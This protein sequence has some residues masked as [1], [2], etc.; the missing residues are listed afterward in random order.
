MDLGLL[1][2]IALTT[3][4]TRDG[5]QSSGL[6]MNWRIATQLVYEDIGD[7]RRAYRELYEMRKKTIAGRLKS[8]FLRVS[9]TTKSDLE[10]NQLD[11]GLIETSSGYYALLEDRKN[12]VINIV[13][14][15]EQKYL[16]GNINED[17]IK[18]LQS[19]EYVYYVGSVDF[20]PRKVKGDIEE[21]LFFVK[22]AARAVI[23]NDHGKFVEEA[24]ENTNLYVG[25]VSDIY[26]SV[27]IGSIEGKDRSRFRSKI[28]MFANNFVAYTISENSDG[29]W[30]L[31]KYAP[32][33]RLKAGETIVEITGTNVSEN[34]ILNKSMNNGFQLGQPYKTQKEAF[35]ALM[36]KW[37][38]DVQ[39]KWR[40]DNT[41]K[42]T[43][44]P[45]TILRTMAYDAAIRELQNPENIEEGIFDSAVTASPLLF[46]GAR[47]LGGPIGIA[48]STAI[49]AG[50]AMRKGLAASKWGFDEFKW[51][52]GGAKWMGRDLKNHI[53]PERKNYNRIRKKLHPDFI[54]NNRLLSIGDLPVNGITVDGKK[55]IP[56]QKTEED[57]VNRWLLTADNKG[58][59][60]IG[61]T[62]NDC[63][64]AT[65]FLNGLVHVE[66]RNP[67][68]RDKVSYSSY[69]PDMDLNP[70][71]SI[72]STVK[73]YLSDGK[74][75]VVSH[76]EEEDIIAGK[77]VHYDKV[78]G[79]LSDL[80]HRAS[81][82]HETTHNTEKSIAHI[83]QILRA[84]CEG[85]LPEYIDMPDLSSLI[86]IPNVV[87]PTTP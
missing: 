14:S 75:R 65:I 80:L 3:Q 51:A 87:H 13:W 85:D 61:F 41:I 8:A 17:G 37:N 18:R 78:Q 6:V 69:M 33:S 82:Q 28:F 4:M 59:P 10:L 68:T 73:K 62:I 32:Y 50:F 49:L 38:D 12:S 84:C 58:M 53:S 1:P 67:K 24:M 44:A 29:E 54:E 15:R 30:V 71:V 20:V 56:A 55:P 34:S 57:F 48:I 52:V 83:V 7:T 27:R 11:N 40:G 39:N 86:H 47:A 36:Q 72:P 74:I 76:I 46:W 21:N 63:T 2:D 77:E 42:I 66:S 19:S 31:E 79:Q 35:I 25:D 5:I 60:S 70:R 9:Y 43:E 45:Y 64:I 81:L 23:S 26:K 16:S 22:Q